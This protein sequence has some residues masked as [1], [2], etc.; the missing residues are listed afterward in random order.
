[1][2]GAGV[3]SRLVGFARPLQLVT[4]DV[5]DQSRLRLHRLPPACFATP[6]NQAHQ[7][8]RHTVATMR[9]MR[10]VSFVDKRQLGVLL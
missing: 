2:G 9:K 1:M 5:N 7:A 4:K 8:L 3:K 6:Q 10:I